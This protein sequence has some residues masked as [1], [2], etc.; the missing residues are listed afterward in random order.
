[1]G[2]KATIQETFQDAAREAAE[3]VID[4][5]RQQQP[6]R[7]SADRLRAAALILEY[8]SKQSTTE[9]T[10][11][12]IAPDI[13]KLEDIRAEAAR[14]RQLRQGSIELDALMQSDKVEV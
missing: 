12:A 9:I 1:M 11:T 2:A 14:R 4:I 13:I 7:G 3:A 10:L 6:A 8:A 5:M